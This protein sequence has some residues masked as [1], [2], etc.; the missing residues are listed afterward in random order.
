MLFFSFKGTSLTSV[1]GIFQ[2]IQGWVGISCFRGSSQPRDRT[3]VSYIGW[4]IL[5]QLH[6]LGRHLCNEVTIKTQNEA[7]WRTSR[8]VSA[9]RFGEPLPLPSTCPSC[10]SHPT[11][12]E[13]CTFKTLLI[14]L[15]ALGLIEACRIF[16][17]GMWTLHCGMWYLVP[18]PGIKP[19]PPTLGAKSLS[20]WITR[21]V[22]WAIFFCDKLV[23]ASKLLLWVLWTT[24]A[25]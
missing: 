7:F 16:S 2:A 8:L 6:H 18:W 4:Q 22:P 1:Q 9:S 10:L 13:L 23:K 5:Y 15:A 21:E 12:P 19:G 14:Q 3:G 11:V 20:H 25:N 24:L 17:C